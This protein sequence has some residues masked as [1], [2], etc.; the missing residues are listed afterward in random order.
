MKLK[1]KKSDFELVTITTL[2]N[3]ATFMLSEVHRDTDERWVIFDE[4]SK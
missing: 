2:D 1:S 4:K 3:I